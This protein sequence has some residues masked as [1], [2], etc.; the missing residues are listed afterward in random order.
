MRRLISALALALAVVLPVHG[1]AQAA[2]AMSV[3]FAPNN[4]SP[5]LLDLF[6]KP[7]LWAR[8]RKLVNV[9]QLAGQQ[10]S[11][12]RVFKTNNYADLT[13]VNAF[14]T[15]RAWHIPLALEMGALKEWDCTGQRA[16]AATVRLLDNVRK[17]SGRVQY[18]AMDEPL[19]ATRR[20]C[21]LSM[22]DA[23]S[24]TADYINSVRAGDSAGSGDA[25]ISVGDVEPYPFFKVPDLERW[26]DMV[27]QAKGKLDFFHLD[28]N[29]NA[30]DVRRDVDMTRDIKDLYAFTQS[31]QIPFGVIF[32]SG[33]NPLNSD[34]LYFEDTM[35]FVGRVHQAIG[36][37]DQAIF[38]S[39]ITRSPVSC[40]I[41]SE[42]CKRAPCTAEDPDY[43]GG[44]SI[45]VNLPDD[46]PD[47]FSHTRL[48]S[49]GVQLLAR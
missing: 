41:S 9:F 39:W 34:K 45:P 31:R 11:G 29:V 5:D 26:V 1:R 7:E 19:V 14:Q 40:S 6:R 21:N 12:S 33:Y 49:Q 25:P 44:K 15:L 23:A 22:D 28:I 30:I 16:A 37:P 32:W 35:K 43:C 10:A 38:E 18:I 27:Q 20:V 2:D 13:A 17:A 48:I 46:R 24:R 4:E 42:A 36:A 3:W 8:T 47:I